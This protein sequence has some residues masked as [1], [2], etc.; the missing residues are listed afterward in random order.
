[1]IYKK[2]GANLSFICNSA[3]YP[4]SLGILL[5]FS[6]KQTMKD[7]ATCER[8]ILHLVA[9]NRGVIC[10][11]PKI[12]K[13]VDFIKATRNHFVRNHNSRTVDMSICTYT[14]CVAKT[15]LCMCSLSTQWIYQRRMSNIS[16]FI[17]EFGMASF[18]KHND[19]SCP[20]NRMIL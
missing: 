14:C 4:G 3:L 1:M 9:E 10:D 11:R 19:S 2:T 16:S 12:I 8:V 13:F 17:Y 15:S 20:Q 18:V 7:S 5:N 6:A